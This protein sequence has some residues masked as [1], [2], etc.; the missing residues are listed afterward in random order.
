M[1]CAVVAFGHG[2]FGKPWHDSIHAIQ[3][4][5][6]STS[7][8]VV[9]DDNNSALSSQNYFNDYYAVHSSVTMAMKDQV[10]V[11]KQ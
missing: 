5:Y 11:N 1:N 6:V 3:D 8:S 10:V 2:P 7:V 9:V 4:N